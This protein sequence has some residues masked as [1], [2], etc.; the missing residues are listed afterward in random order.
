MY[1]IVAGTAVLLA[2]VAGTAGPAQAHNPPGTANDPRL[3]KVT[4]GGG[5]IGFDD[6][7][8]AP[9]SPQPKALRM[10]TIEFGK[11]RGDV[12]NVGILGRALG[13]VERISYK[14]RDGAAI[15]SSPTR[16]SVGLSNGHWLFLRARNSGCADL[17][18]GGGWFKANF[19]APECV[20]DATTEAPDD[21]ATSV[22]EHET[23][24][25]GWQNVLAGNSA[26]SGEGP[27]EGA[28]TIVEKVRIVERGGGTAWV[29]DIRLDGVL[30]AG[31]NVSTH[32]H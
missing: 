3:V 23:S 17:N 27:G 10:H 16:L 12:R 14:F 1:R 29:D 28:G 32:N 11:V 7:R 30:F 31:P 13:D 9:G 5:T 4:D 6:A 21:P 26:D 22:N 25:T 8:N 19:M 2:V 15:T 20:I 18:F 24:Y